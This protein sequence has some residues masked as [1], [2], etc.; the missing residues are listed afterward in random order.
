MSLVWALLRCGEADTLQGLY[1]W[2][3]DKTGKRHLWIKYVAEQAAGHKEQAAEGYM[4]LLNEQDAKMDAYIKE[5]LTDQLFDCLYYTNQWNKLCEVVKGAESIKR[6]TIMLSCAQNQAQLV[7]LQNLYYSYAHPQSQEV[8]TAL[9]ELTNWTNIDE[10]QKSTSSKE[11]FSYYSLIKKIES[12]F[13]ANIVANDGV[14][15]SPPIGLQEAL[16]S[17][18]Q[19]SFQRANCNNTSSNI[20]EHLTDFIILNHVAQKL[21][22]S[23]FS[24]EVST[25]DTFDCSQVVSQSTVRLKCLRWSRL[26]KQHLSSNS[27]L[28]PTN[29]Y[30]MFLDVATSARREGNAVLCRTELERFFTLKGFKEPLAEISTQVQNQTL[31]L[32]V[33]DDDLLRG[34]TELANYMYSN[35]SNQIDAV[36]L[37][38][39]YCFQMIEQISQ[40]ADQQYPDTSSKMLLTLAEWLLQRG[41]TAAT[42]VNTPQLQ[43]L[44]SHLVDITGTNIKRQFF[45]KKNKNSP[46]FYP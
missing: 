29:N 26:F 22:D 46:K 16:H 1:T 35:A 34:F 17:G 9:H 20:P 44:L 23:Q 18:L 43:K 5:F 3:K 7:A 25:A 45:T 31:I 36:N 4:Y 39:A 42:V 37:A 38:S 28:P 11:N 13:I 32:D 41:S 6:E 33:N 30:S 14:T 10:T 27:S 24:E 21:Q 8:Q 12:N 19:E 40:K 15:P 2:V